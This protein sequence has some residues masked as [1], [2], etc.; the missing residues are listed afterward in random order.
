MKETAS[1]K[2]IVKLIS[3]MVALSGALVI[4]GWIFNIGFLKSISP[5]WITMKFDTAGSFVLSGTILYF[6]VRAQEGFYDL[7]QVI[8]FVASLIIMLFMGTLFFSSLFGIHTG[9]EDLFVKDTQAA[10]KTVIPGRPSIPTIINFLLIALG[11]ILSIVS[12]QKLRFRLKVIGIVVGLIGAGAVCGYIMNVPSLYYYIAG[13]NSA[14]ACHTAALFVLLG[15]G[16][17]CL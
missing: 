15:I 16:L 13:I 5:D 11:G 17:L 7:A 12:V 3:F 4:V 14:M 10:I 6:I 9:I 8:I 1:S 2:N